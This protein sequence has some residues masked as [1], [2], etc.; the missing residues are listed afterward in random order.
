MI[1]IHR[2]TEILIPDSRPE[3]SLQLDNNKLI[4]QS[5]N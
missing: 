1:S 5:F 4:E 2:A 3:W